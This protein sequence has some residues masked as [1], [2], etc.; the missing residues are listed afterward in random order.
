MDETWE[1]L[2]DLVL[3]CIKDFEKKGVEAEAFFTANR[4]TEVTIRNSEILTQ[5]NLDDAGAGFRVIKDGR[6]GFASTNTVTEEALLKTGKKASAA[7]GVSSESPGFTLPGPGDVPDVRVYDPEVAHTPVEDMV[8]LAQRMITAA[9]GT[10]PRVVAKSGIVKF[11]HG[12]R[13]VINTQ[14]VNVEEQGSRVAVI[15][16]GVGEDTGEVTGYC[17]DF[18]FSRT[19]DVDPEA[20]GKSV[21]RKVCDMFGPQPI[22]TCKGPVIFGPDA[23]SYQLADVLIDALKGETVVAR[24]SFWTESLEQ[25]VASDMF[26]VTD[27][28]TLENGFSSRTFD[29]EGYPSQDTVLI[30]KGVLKHYLHLSTTAH[31]LNQENTGNA[32]RSPGGFDMTRNIIGSGYRAQPEIYP[33]TL[34]IRPGE[35]SKEELISEVEKGVLIESMDGFAQQGSGLISARLSRA[36]FIKDGTIQY[37]IKGGMV[38]GVGFDW[39]NHISGVGSDAKQFDHA[40][41]PSL[42][43]EDVTVVGA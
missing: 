29:D 32:S 37:S 3:K 21:G 18:V 22:K 20:L 10:D 25:K 42:R 8:D 33:S 36:F 35:K 9:E 26:T 1:L 5:N 31:V 41:V 38:S 7:A 24:R 14:G 40:V 13:G 6:V 2:R 30:H 12:W 39:I 43:V 27:K 17:S 34:V 11:Q 23:G 19:K 4:T 16:G 15:L 28:G